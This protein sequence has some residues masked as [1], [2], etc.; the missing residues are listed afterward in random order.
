[1]HMNIVEAYIMNISVKFQL[2]PPY[3]FWEDFLIFF[4]KFNV[5]V[6]MASNPGNLSNSAVWKKIIYILGRGLLK[7]HFCKT[8][9]KYICSETTINANFHVSHYKSMIAT[10]V[11]IRL[12]NLVRIGSIASAE[13][14]FENVA[15]RT[16][17]GHL[18]IC[19]LTYEPSAQVAQVS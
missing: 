12:W 10:R 19:K 11:L 3:G 2:H 14:S 18:P 5:L 17:D 16:D 7:E 13:M 15:G 4:C 6:A 9:I 8:F 1:M